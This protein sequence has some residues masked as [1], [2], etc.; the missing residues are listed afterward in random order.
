MKAVD[1]AGLRRAI[2][3][4]KIAG[5]YALQIPLDDLDVF[6]DEIE[7]GRLAA[8]VAGDLLDECR[9]HFLDWPKSLTDEKPSGVLEIEQ[10]RLRKERENLLKKISELLDPKPVS[11]PKLTLPGWPS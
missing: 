4:Q 3:E 8:K 6:C 11:P 7:Q 2:R 9:E 1:L 5:T 10:K